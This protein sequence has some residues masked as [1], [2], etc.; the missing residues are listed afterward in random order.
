MVSRTS[1]TLDVSTSTYRCVSTGVKKLAWLAS[2][3]VK[4]IVVDEANRDKRF[5]GRAC[6]SRHVSLHRTLKTIRLAIALRKLIRKL[7]INRLFALALGRSISSQGAGHGAESIWRVSPA[8]R[9][10]MHE[11]NWT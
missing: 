8:T 4:R 1:A 11:G 5:F 2:L 9:K 3:L 10:W 6:M 7:P